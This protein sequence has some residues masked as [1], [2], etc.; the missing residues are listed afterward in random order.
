MSNFV[1]STIFIKPQEGHTLPD[2]FRES[3]V[4]EDGDFTFEQT[5]PTDSFDD[6]VSEASISD[7]NDGTLMIGL[8]TTAVPEAWLNALAA[9]YPQLIIE[10]ENRQ[11]AD[12]TF[13]RTVWAHGGKVLDVHHSHIS[14]ERFVY[15][16][17]DVDEC[18]GWYR[19][20]FED[21]SKGQA[22]EAVRSAQ[23]SQ[24][25]VALMDAL[26][27]ARHE[28][29]YFQ[30]YDLGEDEL[31]LASVAYPAAMHLM[32]AVLTDENV[33]TAPVAAQI[34]CEEDDADAIAAGEEPE[35]PATKDDLLGLLETI[36]LQS[37]LL[38]SL[39][40][41]HSTASEISRMK[42]NVA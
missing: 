4:D 14:R 6:F 8:E 16:G 9:K 11:L 28:L 25:W 7:G 39:A 26:L 18:Q 10:C 40:C 38:L 17:G 29:G 3:L 41:H 27:T 21:E 24:D 37:A 12:G 23:E 13:G 5:A 31:R 32:H 2:A 19:S 36:A 15:F 34:G 30:D 35:A 20:D 42:E 33:D 22:V 1:S